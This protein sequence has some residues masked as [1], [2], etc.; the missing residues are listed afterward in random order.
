MDKR[1]KRIKDKYNPYKLSSDNENGI[2][3]V[4]FNNNNRKRNVKISKEVFELFDEIEKEDA[5]IIQKNRRYIEQ[6][7]LTEIT[8]WKRTKSR[9]VHFEDNVA[10]KDEIER[11]VKAFNE[12]PLEHKKNIILYFK[13]NLSFSQ[14]AK[15][16][17][18]TKMGA[19]YKLDKALEELRK[20]FLKKN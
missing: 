13:Q 10:D 15:I 1:P 20:I 8:L 4:S 11:L 19:K 9:E 7:E 14:I 6:S 5:R 2:Y 12:L 16:E 18:C 3:I 17:G